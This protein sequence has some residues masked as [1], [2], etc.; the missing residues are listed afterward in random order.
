[1]NLFCNECRF[2]HKDPADW[3]IEGP[4]EFDKDSVINQITTLEIRHRSHRYYRGGILKGREQDRKISMPAI[5]L[6]ED[7]KN[8]LN[9]KSLRNG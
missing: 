3:V 8:S 5:P 9:R 2:E 1:M 6:D 7:N 4:R